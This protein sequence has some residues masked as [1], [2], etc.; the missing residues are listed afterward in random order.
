LAFID[1]PSRR[2][3]STVVRFDAEGRRARVQIL[4][5]YGQS[6]KDARL[7]KIMGMGKQLKPERNQAE[8]NFSHDSGRRAAASA[9]LTHARKD[10]SARHLQETVRTTLV[11]HCRDSHSSRGA[12]QRRAPP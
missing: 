1:V 2:I 12:F 4:S 3:A 9:F 10:G 8:P 6:E 5:L 11:N 7:R